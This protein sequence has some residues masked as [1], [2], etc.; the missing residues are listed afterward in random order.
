MV[1]FSEAWWLSLN[2]V[3]TSASANSPALIDSPSPLRLL[4]CL[5]AAILRG[6]GGVRG[7]FMSPIRVRKKSLMLTRAL[8]VVGPLATGVA[9]AALLSDPA[10]DAYNVRVGTQTFAGLYQF[11]TN[12]L[13]VETAQAIQTMGS[14]V[15]KFY[16]GSD[17]PLQSRVSLGPNITNLLTLVR[18]EPSYHRVLD[19][20]F[21]HFVMWAYP[22]GNSWPFDGYSASERADDYREIYDLTAYLLT[23][24]NNSGK[25]FYLGHWEGDWY[26]LPNFFTATNPSPIAIQGMIEWLNNRQKAVDD[27]RLAVAH[28]N[29]NVFNYAEVNRV[30]DATS[31][32]TNINQRMINRVI[33]FVTNLDYLRIRLTT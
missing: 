25:T 26:L 20:P 22:F 9:S 21:Q 10:V 14:G 17:A 29:V 31:G 24:Y 30:L 32:N 18:D 33:P 8:L 6:E 15:I 23:N 13:L 5:R 4:R 12:T 1:A 3:R 28:S 19:M 7:W 2:P 16:L 27:A 11:T